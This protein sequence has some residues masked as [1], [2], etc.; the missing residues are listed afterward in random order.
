MNC[1]PFLYITPKSKPTNE[2]NDNLTLSMQE[3]LDSHKNKTGIFHKGKFYGNC[4]FNGFHFCICGQRSE[5]TDY[6]ILNKYVT[7]SLC[8][9]Y[10]KDHRSECPQKELNIVE[11]IIQEWNDKK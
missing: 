10:L 11:K 2:V 5:N 6:L 4:S 3:I 8:V 1:E 7:N 9:H